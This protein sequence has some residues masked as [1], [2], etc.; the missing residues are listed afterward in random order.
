MPVPSEGSA[1]MP[2]QRVGGGAGRTGGTCP[3]LAE[4]LPS[5]C[6]ARG[7]FADVV[8]SL[9]PT[10][11][12]SPCNY[13]TQTLASCHLTGPISPTVFSLSRCER[14]HTA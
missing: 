5:P 8:S 3:A 12:I 7:C 1:F 2:H 6:V 4:P 13:P 10:R 11:S 14:G 9:A